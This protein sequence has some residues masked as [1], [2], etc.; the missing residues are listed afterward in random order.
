MLSEKVFFR[1]QRSQVFENDTQEEVEPLTLTDI[2]DMPQNIYS[3]TVF[4]FENTGNLLS[5]DSTT[6][7]IQ[8]VLHKGSNMRNLELAQVPSFRFFHIKK[9]T[10]KSKEEEIIT[11]QFI[12]IDPQ[13]FYDDMKAQEGF[14]T[15]I[16]STISHEMR[17]PLNAIICQQVV[18]QQLIARFEAFLRSIEAILREDKVIEFELILDDFREDNQVIKTSSKLL[19]YHVEDVLGMA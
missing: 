4:V 14:T 11:L 10:A 13:I 5:F 16:N 15:L 1:Y 6:T 17:N 8:Q 9:C 18:H 3:Q 12:D 2:I 19:L 7:H